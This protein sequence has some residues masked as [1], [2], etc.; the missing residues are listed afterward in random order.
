MT[1]RD[2]VEQAFTRF[3][4]QPA[5]LS[6]NGPQSYAQ[7][8]ERCLRRIAQLRSLGVAPGERV[9]AFL[10]NT[11]EFL[12]LYLTCALDGVVLV[13]LNLRL[14]ARELC[15]ILEDAGAKV[16]F[17]DANASTAL[18]QALA[19]CAT[20]PLALHVDAAPHAPLERSQLHTPRPSDPAQLYYTSGTTGRPKGVVLSHANVASHAHAAC[21]E[22]G[23]N[24]TDVWG[25][26]APMFHLA[27]AWACFAVT[28]AGGA[29]AFLPRFEAL[30]CFACLATHGVTLTNLVPTMLQA[31]VAIGDARPTDSLRLVLSGG[32]PI[33][34]ELVRRVQELFGCEYVQTYG[35]TETSPFLTVSLLDE[36]LRALDDEEQFFYR[37]RTGR[38]FGGVELRVVNEEGHEVPADGKSVR[39]I[40]AR[41]PWVFE[42]YWQ[43]PQATAD[44]FR[45][46]W[47][48]TG[49]LA[50]IEPRG[51]LHIVDRKKDII[52]TGGETVYSTEVENAL[53]THQGVA[54][55]AVFPLPDERWGEV[56]GAAVV[57]C[58]KGR[59]VKLAELIGHCRLFLAPYKIPRVVYF[60]D[61]LPLTGSGKV[62]KRLLRERCL[63][64]QGERVNP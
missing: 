30:A 1:L 36:E 52:L 29:H 51:F 3:A 16:L 7:L 2:L 64:L 18:D 21:A 26:C 35:L 54:S 5:L 14:S 44:A 12:E 56:V 46:G 49:D 4:T 33:A 50:T 13:P 23:L 15:G 32:A 41:G 39:E 59:E 53:Y 55:A 28:L 31:M 11:P 60:L 10:H 17:R 63:D 38:P 20:P 24:S 42:G 22:F 8:E 40:E 58:N 47:F 37:S 34:P 9:A 62:Q 25:H 48:L 57:L 27:D 6:A 45:D 19:E 43:Q 61:E